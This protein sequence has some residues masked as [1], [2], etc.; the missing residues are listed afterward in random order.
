MKQIE[1]FF[2]EFP[3]LES[4]R[5]VLRKIS[6]DDQV[7][8]FNYC[9]VP[10][11]SKYTVWDVHKTMD[12]TKAFIDFVLHRYESQKVGPWG[13]EH[14][15]TKKIIG[16]C[17]FVNWDNR[18]SRAEL[19]YVLSRAFWNQGY[20]S[21]VITRIIDF[22]FRDLNLVRIE[23]RCHPDNIGSTRV[24]E[25]SGMKFEG[26]L[27]RHILAKDD[28]QDVKIYSIIKD[29]YESKLGEVPAFR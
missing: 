21:E 10:E 15:Q 26:I 6:L 4:E 23:A 22:G 14:K 27:R 7:E 1:D 8:I 3:A 11:V 17:S 19:G 2:Q 5:T 28:Y 29:D 13:I 20:M 25:K 12:D 24:M 9:S 16:S 18:N